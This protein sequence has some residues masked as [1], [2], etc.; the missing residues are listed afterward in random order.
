MKVTLEGIKDTAAFAKAGVE[1]PKYDVAAVQ[2]YSRENPVWLHFGAGNIFRGFVGSLQQ[3]LL[4]EGLQKAGIQTLSVY[5]GAIIDEVFTPHNKLTMEVT[6]LP[7]TNVELKVIGSVVHGYKPNGSAPEDEAEVLSLITKPSLQLVSYTITE[8]GYSIRGLD[9]NYLD[10]IVKD[11]ASGPSKVGHVISW[12]AAL[13]WKRYQAGAYPIAMVSMDN[14]SHNGDKLRDAVVE[15]AEG[16]LAK[17]FVEQGFIDYLK[18]RNKVGFPWTMIDK[19]TPRPDPSIA[20]QLKERGIEDMDPI[21]TARGSYIAPFVNAEKPQYL[22][23]EDCFP[24]G[25]PPLEKAGVLF[26]DGKGVDLCE[27]MKVTTCLNPLHTALAVYG[28]LLGFQRVALEMSDPQLLALVK[29]LGYDEGLKVV[30]DPKILNPRD[31][32]DEVITKRIPNRCLLDTPQ[33][34]ATDTSQKIPARFGGVLQNYQKKGFD[35]TH[36]IAIPLAIAGWLRYLL[37][38]DDEGNAFEVSDDPLLPQLQAQLAGIKLGDPDS[39]GNKL[40]DILTNKD[41]F[42]VDLYSVGLGEKIEG[43]FK[44][45]LAG[46][47]AVRNTLVKYLG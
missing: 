20:K 30:D 28:C 8:K 21:K 2:Q 10:Q 11:L 40:H 26:T 47:H 25:R 15:V 14:C 24:N 36:L 17:G 43:L 7:D 16:W 13:L 3:T 5:D 34:I 44:E 38:I 22:V 6:L 39:V 31:F 12:T 41:I 29:T 45:E 32:L 9:G 37:G 35:T 23:V 27:R 18:D 42:V 1:L 33:R 4:N 19:I 46:P